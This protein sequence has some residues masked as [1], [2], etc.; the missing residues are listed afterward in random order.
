MFK[1][2]N[3]FKVGKLNGNYVALLLISLFL[4]LILNMNPMKSDESEEIVFTNTYGSSY[5]RD[6]EQK[7]SS[8]LSKVSGA[9]EVDVLITVS[10]GSESV[11]AKN[12]NRKT[13]ET[14]ENKDTLKKE[15]F[16]EEVTDE[17]IYS[18][19]QSGRPFILYEKN[20]TIEGVL[21]VAEGGDDMNIVNSFIRTTESLLNVPSHKISVLKMQN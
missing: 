1:L 6:M 15:M 13:E 18:D 3:T 2:K 5:E 12:T 9:G 4:L 17:V 11:I 14:T 20:P 10:T 16:E 19:K 21:I 8:I 7:L